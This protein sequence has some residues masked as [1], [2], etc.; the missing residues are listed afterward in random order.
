MESSLL[1]AGAVAT[2]SKLRGVSYANMLLRNAVLL[3]SLWLVPCAPIE[4]GLDA[5]RLCCGS[6]NSECAV[7]AEES[8]RAWQLRN[9][10]GTKFAQAF[11]RAYWHVTPSAHVTAMLT[12]IH[13][14]DCG[15]ITDA[16]QLYWDST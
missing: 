6:G 2:A 13:E 7:L 16:M 10:A 4:T 14:H 9:R 15:I 12:H 8:P 3:A 5:A 1:L 11:P